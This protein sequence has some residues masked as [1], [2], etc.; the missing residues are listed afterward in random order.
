M[1][2]APRP[3]P[4]SSDR[5]FAAY[6]WLVT[7]SVGVHPFTRLA[8]SNVRWSSVRPRTCMNG[9]GAVSREIGH[10]RVPA[11][12]ERMTGTTIRLM[13]RPGTGF[14]NADHALA[15]DGG[16]FDRRLTI[17]FTRRREVYRRVKLWIDQ[18]KTRNG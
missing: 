2:N 7:I 12:P 5:V 1:V 9:L 15:R 4:S 11:P 13:R 6:A 8:R 10:S 3:A 18:V 16:R 14:E 17:A